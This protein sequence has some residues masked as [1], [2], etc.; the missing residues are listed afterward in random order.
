[1]LL[2]SPS[3]YLIHELLLIIAGVGYDILVDMLKYMSPSHVVKICIS[4]ERK[5]LPAGAFW[6]DK[7]EFCATNIIEMNSARQDSYNR[8]YVPYCSFFPFIFRCCLMTV[9][10]IFVPN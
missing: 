10:C 9:F 6:L 5:N 7:E 2:L 4:A 3:F 8:S 1:M